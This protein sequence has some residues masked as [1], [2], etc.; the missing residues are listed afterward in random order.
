MVDLLFKHGAVLDCKDNVGETPLFSAMRRSRGP[1][2]NLLLKLGADVCTT[3]ACGRTVLFALPTMGRESYLDDKGAPLLRKG[4]DPTRRDN[5]GQTFLHVACQSASVGP[6][7]LDFV[8]E[9]IRSGLDV[10]AQDDSGRTPL[11]NAAASGNGDFVLFLLSLGVDGDKV[12]SEG[13]TPLTEAF[14]VLGTRYNLRDTIFLPL[15]EY[16]VK[17]YAS[18]GTDNNILFAAVENKSALVVGPL[19]DHVDVGI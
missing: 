12:D 8:R 2:F 10:D 5:Q 6:P 14:R 17:P 1:I 15:L 3:D 7:Y 4:L 19:L 16:G 18:A 9:V 13:R 11:M